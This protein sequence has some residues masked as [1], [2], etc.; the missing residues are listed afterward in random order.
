MILLRR[1][2]KLKTKAISW[3]LGY[4][5]L[6]LLIAGS[7]LRVYFGR[8]I[9]DGLPDPNAFL[10]QVDQVFLYSF[11]GLLITAAVFSFF[12]VQSFF[13]PL[14]ALITKA[15]AIKKGDLSP[16]R[17][18]PIKENRGEWYQLDLLLNKIWRDL[19]RKKDDVAKERGELEAVIT[20]ATDAILA[21][22]KDMN[23]RYYNAPMAILFDQKDEGNWG[24]KLKEVIR[25]QK[26]IEGFE[27]AFRLKVSQQVEA[28]QELAAD[29]SLH[30][31]QVSISP[32]VDDKKQKVRGAVAIFHDIS[33]H[34]KLDKVRMDFVAN[35]SHEL[36]TP[37]TSIQGYIDF[38]KTSCKGQSE[39]GE[40]FE[41]VESNIERLG[42]TIQDLLEL[43]RIEAA[44]N[45]A[46]TE[47]DTLA[48]TEDVMRRI[49]SRFSKK[50]QEL[51]FRYQAK[52]IVA[53]GDLLQHV[54][55]NLIE[56]ANKYCGEG[57]QI[58]VNWGENPEAWTLSVKDN[59]PG[60]ES[61]HQG[62]LF[63]RFYRV[64]DEQTKGVKGTG[65]GLSIVRHCMLKMG[66][67]VDIKSAPGL[68]TEF[69]CY[70]PKS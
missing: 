58:K 18:E 57:A 49:E 68:G 16:K 35:A 62:R 22:D 14:A 31:F 67:I 1:A 70:F 48:V 53:N 25:S 44:E 50:N 28:S 11:W 24:R 20:A 27:K 10:I 15:K 17:S 29:A 5:V 8:S 61:Y 47:V 63:E 65:L 12:F 26:I 2:R 54:L 55:T 13:N 30:H 45:A 52:N 66:G 59:G 9:R 33:E 39:L 37:L 3:L 4:F 23:I 60:I 64:R 6:N 34:K 42:Q 46:T 38:I 51:I 56:N 32:F 7:I 21:V 19:K 40:A 36:K 41:V 69:I 43:S